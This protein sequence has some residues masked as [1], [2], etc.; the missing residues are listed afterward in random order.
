MTDAPRFAAV[1]LDA[2]S[3]LAGIEGID[4]LAERRDA[5]VAAR[6]AELTDL[7]MRG[8]LPLDAVYGERLVAI[9]PTVRELE[10][11]AA[12]YVTAL[13]P[14]AVECVQALREAG[15][16]VAIVSGGIRQ[17]LLPMAAALGIS[18]ADVRA[19]ELTFDADGT[20][21]GYRPSPLATQRGKYL[22]I[23]TLE[24]PHPV[25]GVGDG[26]TDVHMRPA[27]DTFAAFTGWV[28]RDPV[29]RAAD[30]VLS[31]FDHLRTLVLG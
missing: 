13:A 16:R 1:V 23:E 17:A 7:A 6:I 14:G 15:V 2:D 30:H 18:D 28:T 26:A 20:Y 29:V 9:R 25:L 21:V 5:A 27:A 4:W 10:A 24:L 12:A 11:L 19:V 3:T 22:A 31:S 8:A